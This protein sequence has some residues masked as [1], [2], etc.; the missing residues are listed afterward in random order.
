MVSD[1]LAIVNNA[2]VDQ[3][4]LSSKERLSI[5]DNEIKDNE[6][7]QIKFHTRIL[8]GFLEHTGFQSYVQRKNSE[9][10]LQPIKDNEIK[11]IKF[12]TSIK[13]NFLYTVLSVG[14]PSYVQRKRTGDM[15]Q[16][17]FIEVY[18]KIDEAKNEIIQELTKE[19]QKNRIIELTA[20]VRGLIINVGHFYDSPT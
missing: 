1:Y 20:Q 10:M 12:H 18:K 14:L 19:I 17:V 6:I 11:P 7:K 13:K 16:Q 4:F 15:L 5:K 8:Y 3:M 9:N 2:V